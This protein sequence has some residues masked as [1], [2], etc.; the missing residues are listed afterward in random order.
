MRRASPYVVVL[1]AAASR[2][3]RSTLAANLAVYLRGLA[4]DLP[5][6]V[7]S[8]D[9]GHDPAQTFELAGNAASGV[10]DLFAGLNIEEQL[11]LGQFG[12]EYLTTGAL[13]QIWPSR[14]RALL[15]ES[16]FPGILIVDAG[17]LGE[18]PAAAALQAADLVL[19][20]LKD[21]A[22]LV[23]LSGIRR[24][25]KAGGGND[26]MLWLIPAMIEDPQQQKR[27]L[28]LLR[29]AARERGCQ[30]LDGEF[31]VDTQLPQATRGAGGS[32][33]TRMP[34]SRAHQ[35]L[36]HLAQLV[37]QRFE[38]GTDSSCR[39]QRLRLD[40][41]LPPRF[42]RVEVICPLCGELACFDLA[43]YCE[44]LP[45][46][47]RWLLHADCLT[48][49]MSGHRLQPFWGAGQAAVVRTGVEADGLISQ[50]RL[51]LPDADGVH[52]ETDLFQPAADSG[53]QTLVRRA[54]GRTLAEQFPGLMMIYPAVSGRRALSADWY[55]SCAALRKRLRAGLAAEF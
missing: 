36:H 19:S 51:V 48:E 8:F 13:P 44:S 18:K 29:F 27:Q 23:A 30:V 49:L 2:V 55:R 12:V 14:L 22:G 38:S 47:R 33:L 31:V 20:P 10:C 1:A 11:T 28:E 32:V 25:I 17:S 43:H 40:G 37:L 15:R 35:L 26:Q 52:Y 3:G 24:E 6:A 21:A 41:A 53:W 42:R 7:V 34:D 45:H 9:P 46:R 50:L 16:R 5:L 4:E 54:T 39:L